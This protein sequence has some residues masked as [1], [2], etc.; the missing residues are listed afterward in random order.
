MRSDLRYPELQRPLLSHALHTRFSGL[1]GNG[2][3]L[4]FLGK[5]KNIE[6]YHRFDMLFS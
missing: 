4:T 6:A 5:K 3:G 1:S 2:R